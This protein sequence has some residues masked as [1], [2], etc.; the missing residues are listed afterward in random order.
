MEPK[1]HS[2]EYWID[3]PEPDPKEYTDMLLK[4]GFKVLEYVEHKFKPQGFTGLWLL[5]ESH[6]ALHVWPEANKTYINIASCN[7]DMFNKFDEL[8]EEKTR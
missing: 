5:A 7:L 1:I 3:D 2:K 6:L 4:S 8:M